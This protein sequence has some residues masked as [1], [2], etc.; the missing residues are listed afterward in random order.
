MAKTEKVEQPV[1]EPFK[2]VNKVV[3]EVEELNLD[4]KVNVVSL[5]KWEVSFTRLT[6][7]GMGTVRIMPGGV[8]KLSRN[9][10]IAQVQSGN[11]LFA[12]TDGAGSH[13]T[14]YI[15]DKQTR[16]E[17]GFEGDGFE[18]CILTAEKVKAMFAMTQPKF[19]KELPNIVVTRTEKNAIID[20]IRTLG[21]NDY[22]KI[23]VVENY[24][25]YKL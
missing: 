19:E 15:D 9:E 24:T 6:D 1:T 4:A 20:F 25:H 16:V 17:L 8:A 2:K 7:S 18:Q 22:A 10:I 21:L 13:A 11:A 3:E 12:G 5:A 23:K 14:L